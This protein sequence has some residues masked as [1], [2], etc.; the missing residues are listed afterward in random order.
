MRRFWRGDAGL[1]PD[2][3]ARLT[4]SA[5]LFNRRFRKP[6]ASVNFVAS[7]D[8]FTLADV[9]AYEHKH[10]EAESARTTTT[11]TTRIAA[12]NWG[13][14][15]PT[16]DP[17]ILET[18]EPRRALADRD[19]LMSLGTPM[20]LAGDEFAAARRHGN[21]NAYCQDNEMSWLD[22]ERGEF[23]ATDRQMT[24]Y[25]RARRLHCANNIRCCAKRAFYSAI[26]KCCRA[27]YDV[28]W[29]DERGTRSRSRH[30]R[31][32]KAARSRCA[33]RGRA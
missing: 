12:A 29:F 7:H 23:A 14:E 18:R 27:C 19:L 15:G 6:W 20:V 22:W 10:N 8:G 31:T 2:L 32:R 33:A 30:G 25:R 3:A 28:G 26:V 21:N 24:E 5:E 13:V 4:G 1:R 16:D 9:T 11:A 17:A